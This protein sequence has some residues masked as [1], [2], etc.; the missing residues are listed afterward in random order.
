MKYCSNCGSQL[1]DSAK[2]CGNCG[3]P[4]T[5]SE[6]P[7]QPKADD[8][9]AGKDE[10][11]TLQETS[12]GENSVQEHT[13]SP[14]SDGFFT[15]EAAVQQPAKRKKTGLI[16]G[17]IAAIV[18]IAA[19]VTL[20]FVLRNERSRPFTL[21]EGAGNWEGTIRIDL[22][23]LMDL[24]PKMMS[25]LNDN[26]LNDY[27]SMINDEKFKNTLEEFKKAFAGQELKMI[28]H[29]NIFQDGNGVGSYYID[30]D[31]FETTIKAI[32]KHFGLDGMIPDGDMSSF[33]DSYLPEDIKKIFD[34]DA[35][36]FTFSIEGDKICNPES[37]KTFS[38]LEFR[39]DDIVITFDGLPDNLAYLK[40][41]FSELRFSRRQASKTEL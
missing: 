36:K 33:I 41:L 1:D 22:G 13:E 18:V 2:I 31:S 35:S 11:L 10:V 32:F 6:L 5:T 39:G 12:I 26:S 27:S 16:I 4:F 30:R 40:E 23:K 37:D 20:F 14:V 19:A 28:Y 29:L 7:L 15:G 34:E 9:D 24:F 8:P 21:E 38:K 25:S 3:T 17:I